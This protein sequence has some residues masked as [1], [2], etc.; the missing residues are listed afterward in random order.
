M[1]TMAQRKTPTQ[2]REPVYMVDFAVYKPEDE[3]KI[4]LEECA[5]SAWKWKPDGQVA[6]CTSQQQQQ[7]SIS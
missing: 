1:R 3:L 6:V 4:N 5:E 7:Q 2:L